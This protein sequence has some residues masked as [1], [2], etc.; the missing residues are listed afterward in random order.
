M[1]VQAGSNTPS[2]VNAPPGFSGVLTDK[3]REQ[4][5]AGLMAGQEL[6]PDFTMRQPVERYTEADHEMWGM[7]YE[8]QEALLPGRVCDELLEGLKALNLRRDRMPIF[9]EINETLMDA[10]GWQIVTVPGLVPDDVFFTHLANRRFPASW[11]MRKPEQ[12]DYLQEPDIFHD[13][14]GHVP[15]LINPVFADY[16]EAYGKGGLK[17]MERGMLANFARLYWYTVEFGLIRTAKGL[18]IYGAGIVSSKGE[19]IYCLESASPNRIG[20]DIR[21]IMRTGY[22]I[23][24]F[25]KTYFVIDSFDQLF[26]STRQDFGPIYEDVKRLP[27]VRASDVLDTDVVITRGTGEGW[28]DWQDTADI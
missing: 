3:L 12:I 28:S 19:S 10:T 23:D 7:L 24:T 22:R 8:R 5:E 13:M 14:F 21:R 17:A 20:F 4:F 6:R 26:Q 9:D 15:L 11:W 1:T 2:S 18:R 16:M 27:T 25:Q